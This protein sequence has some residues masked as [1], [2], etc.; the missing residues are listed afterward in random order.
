MGS[1]A[2]E[3]GNSALKS[4]LDAYLFLTDL[5]TKQDSEL[6][7]NRFAR[8][9]ALACAVLMIGPGLTMRIVHIE[10]NVLHEEHVARARSC[11]ILAGMLDTV[12]RTTPR[13]LY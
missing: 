10:R 8:L 11:E 13:P 3:R 1:I 6:E 2:A 7:F 9:P 4:C 12:K 5:L